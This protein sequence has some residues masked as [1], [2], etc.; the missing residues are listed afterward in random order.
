M[1]GYDEKL[2]TTHDWDLWLKI[3]RK[4]PFIHLDILQSMYR[5]HRNN[6]SKNLDRWLGDHI[7]VYGQHIPKKNL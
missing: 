2:F 7:A 4:Y 3:T 5:I 6:A 1:G